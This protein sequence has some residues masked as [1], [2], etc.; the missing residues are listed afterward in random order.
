MIIERIL[1]ALKIEELRQRF[2]FTLFI[3]LIF[4]LGA[5]V[6]LPG[7]DREALGEIF[8]LQVGTILNFFNTFSG[9]A[10]RNFSIFALGIIPY[11]SASIIVQIMTAVF[12]LFEKLA[13]EG[14]LGRRKIASYTRYLTIFL[15]IIQSIGIISGLSNIT[16]SSGSPVVNTNIGSGLFTFISVI[17]LTTGTA[18]VMWMGEKINERGFG[19]GMSLIIFT[20]ILSSVPGTILQS[21]RLLEV[22]ELALF[23]VIFVVCIII[24]VIG[25]IVYVETALR[26]IPIQYARRMRGNRMYGGQNTFLPLKINPSGVIPPIFASSILAFPASLAA[27]VQTPWVQSLGEQL[28]PGRLLYNIIFVFFIFFFCFFY[29]SI[30]FNPI[31]ISE[32]LKEQGGFVPG[33]R[34]GKK[35][36]EYLNLVL[37]RLIFGGAIYLSIICIIPSVLYNSLSIPFFFGGTAVLIVVGV[38]LD[39]SNQMETFLVN[40]NYDSLLK[41]KRKA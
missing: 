28:T 30:Q 41:K 24:A 13:S 25:G 1:N 39:L 7:I 2:L 38:A 27:F 22:G 35:T 29:T 17:T 34:P 5:H 36:A 18:F 32:N 31:K 9:G 8:D 12:P 10:L 3:L 23:T 6:P 14:E 33:V 37:S 40:Q 16:S 11:I 15:S 26:K 21:F 20:G 19:N 4:R